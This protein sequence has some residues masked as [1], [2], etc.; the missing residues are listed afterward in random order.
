MPVIDVDPEEL[1][2]LTSQHDK[3]EDELLD[4]LFNVG[5]EYEGET[6]DGEFKLEFE[7]DRLDW[8]SVEGIAR[9][10]RYHYGEDRGVD[11]PSTN[12]AE[13]SIEVD[14]T[15]EER[16]YVTGA[17]VR[18][19]DL[20]DGVLDSLIQLQEKLHATMGRAR[21]KGAIGVHDLT[22][23]KGAPAAEGREKSIRY[24]SMD[25]DDE[26]F[27]PLEGDEEMSPR[28]VIEEHHIGID[29]ADLVADLDR[30]PAIYDDIG[31]FSFP[32]VVN[33]RRT[34]VTEDSR[35]LLIE[36]TGTN[37]WTID[38][39]LSIVCYMLAA[40]GGQLEAVEVSYAEGAPGEY[41]GHTM[42]KPDFSTKTK[43]VSHDRVETLLGVDLDTETLVDCIERSGLDVSIEDGETRLDDGGQSERDHNYEVEIP[44]YRVDVLHPVDVVDDIGRAYGFNT[45][46]PRYPDVTT[47]GGR[48]ERSRL[49]DAVREM[50]IG[51]GFE[52]LLNFYMTSE[53]KNFERM[54]VDPGTDVVGGGEPVTIMET[55][56]EEYTM[57][58]TWALPSIMQVLENNTHRA[59][60]QHL[61][62]IGLAAWV[63]ES[64][65]TNVAEHQTVAAAMA[66]TEVSYEDIRARMQALTRQFEADLETPAT[67]HPTFISGRC[68]E[69]IIDG[70]SVGVIGEVHPEV[71]VEHDLEVPVVA[72]EFRLD[73]LQ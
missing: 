45:L 69:V 21:A 7:P 62:D 57:L 65:N 20:S 26:R 9:A 54:N 15:P 42:T 67:E 8:L 17:I 37:Q 32:P 66:D 11:I 36:M 24:T 43:T 73:A 19:I 48:H 58:R 52:D 63:D 46:E 30:Y 44:P 27:V 34:E 59:Y 23:L 41:A 50:L 22:M 39:M 31:L 28:E 5:I 53:G 16:P 2:T 72:V 29:Y 70:E 3:P 64:E 18:G 25:P 61:A 55:Y 33:G 12:D 10:L 6:E 13:W 47:I 56:S 38:H 60:P 4:D 1:R 68:A 14:G 40:R 71:I 35:D 49:E 51:L